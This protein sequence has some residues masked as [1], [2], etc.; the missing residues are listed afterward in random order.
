MIPHEKKKGRGFAPGPTFG[1]GV[2]LRA[3]GVRHLQLVVGVDRHVAGAE[4]GRRPQ[5]AAGRVVALGLGSRD[6]AD[7]EQALD[8]PAA[9]DVEDH[10]AGIGDGLAGGRPSVHVGRVLALSLLAASV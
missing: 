3:D 10:R 1:E 7:Q 4:Q 5:H 2:S 9:G 6:A 8:R